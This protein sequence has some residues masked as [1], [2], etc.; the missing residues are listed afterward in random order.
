MQLTCLCSAYLFHGRRVSRKHAGH[1]F[2][3]MVLAPSIAMD[4]KKNVDFFPYLVVD[5]TWLDCFCHALS[6]F[7]SSHPFV[8]G[9]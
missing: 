5:H 8:E 3:S 9:W 4:A 7:N 2:E 6:F 1:Y